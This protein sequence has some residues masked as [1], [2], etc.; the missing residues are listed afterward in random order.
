[1]AVFLVSDDNSLMTGAKL[2]F[3]GAALD[4]PTQRTIASAPCSV[5]LV[6]PGAGLWQRRILVAFDGSQAARGAFDF[7][8]QL[9]K[10]AKTRQMLDSV[11]S[12][13]V[14]E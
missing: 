1:M 6:P 9:A 12:S 11:W 13:H 4:A 10:P 3:P 5:L 8:L 7:A 14:P 2:V